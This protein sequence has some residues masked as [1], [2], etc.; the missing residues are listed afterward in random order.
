MAAGRK[1]HRREA[2]LAALLTE[3]TL[4]EAAAKAGIAERTLKN[5]LRQPEFQAEYAA[6]RQGVL[7]RTVGQLLQLSGEAVDALRRNLTCGKPAAEVKAADLVLSHAARGHDALDVA[8]QLAE[9][10]AILAE[11]RARGDGDSEARAGAAAAGDPAGGGGP[12]PG[13]GPAYGAAGPAV[14]AGGAEAGAVAVDDPLL[15]GPPDDA[16]VQPPGR[17]IDGRR[18][19]GA[20]DGPG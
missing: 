5:W 19:T 9:L 4:A 7:E 18:G 15:A 3:K 17:E 14:R 12:G 8:A 6:R 1:K 16:P 20:E 10:K 13:G 2:A 11:V